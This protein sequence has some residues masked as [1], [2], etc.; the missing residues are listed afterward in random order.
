MRKPDEWY[1]ILLEELCDEV[2]QMDVDE[3]NDSSE[4]DGQCEY[5]WHCSKD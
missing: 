5:C 1:C 3:L 2:T 4:C